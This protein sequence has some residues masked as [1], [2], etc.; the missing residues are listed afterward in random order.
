MVRYYRAVQRAVCWGRAARRADLQSGPIGAQVYEGQGVAHEC[1]VDSAGQPVSETQLA[2]FVVAPAARLGVGQRVACGTA[3]GVAAV[4]C[5]VEGRC[6]RKACSAGCSGP[7]HFSGPGIVLR[8][9]QELRSPVVS[10][11][12]D[13]AAA[14]PARTKST[15]NRTR[16]GLARAAAPARLPRITLRQLAGS[17]RRNE[18]CGPRISL[19]FTVLLSHARGPQR[20]TL[21]MA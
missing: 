17:K 4:L 12:T 1:E 3:D 8:M 7:Y 21:C 20:G 10:W 6:E 19:P 13:C 11:R 9:A 15:A 18:A 5:G 16:S 2:V 14:E